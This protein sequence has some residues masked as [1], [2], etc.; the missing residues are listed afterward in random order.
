MTITFE[1]D[2]DVILYALERILSYARRT[3]QPFVAQCVWWLVLIIRLEQGLINHIENLHG[4]TVI[5]TEQ[6]SE[7]VRDHT[8][9]DA[10]IIQDSKPKASK[11]D[12]QD[13][14]LKKCKQF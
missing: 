9:P 2:N 3:K 11:R 5:S 7:V 8:V 12:H 1:N 10:F 14:I 6:H 13:T 4:R